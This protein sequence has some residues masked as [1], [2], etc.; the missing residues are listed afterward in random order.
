MFQPNATWRAYGFAQGTIARSGGREDNG[1]VGAGGSYQ[2]SNLF[3]VEGEV[4][5]GDLGPGGR[6]GTSFQA[7]EKTNLYLNYSLDNER[8]ANGLRWR[9]GNF[10]SGMKT[11]LNDASSVYL[12]ERTRTGGPQTGLTHAT[13]INVKAKERWSPRAPKPS[14]AR[15]AM[16]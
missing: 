1:R 12:E 15:C 3:S 4:S 7:S 5:D 10:V 2:V 13:G 6:I 11:R 16:R 14:S 8:T 9:R